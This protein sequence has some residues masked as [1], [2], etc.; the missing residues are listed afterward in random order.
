VRGVDSDDVRK[1]LMSSMVTFAKRVGVKLVAEGIETKEE[2]DTLI[3]IGVPYG[4][5]FYFTKPVLPF[6]A[7]ADVTPDH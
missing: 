2:L 1:Q 7:D 4:Q 3:G 6:P 5:G